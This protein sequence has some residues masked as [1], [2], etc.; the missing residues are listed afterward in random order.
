MGYRLLL[1]GPPASGKGTQASAL[2]VT[3]RVPHVSTGQLFRDTARAG[4]ERG[5]TVRSFI[6]K[7]QLVP[8]AITIDV[9]RAWLAGQGAEPEFIFDG[10]PRTLP[11]ATAFDELM[12]QRE[13]RLGKV[14]FLDVDEEE[15]LARVLGRLGC[16]NCGALYHA[17]FSP[18]REAGHCDRCGQALRRRADDTEATVRER[19]RQY[20]DLSRPVVEHY[21]A[22]GLLEEIAGGK[23]K[24]QV[25]AEL[26]RIA[27]S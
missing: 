24:Q 19:L 8:D 18:P 20:R 2:S 5:D 3:L 23:P 11:Q 6:D 12:R 16:A 14:I 27:K 22:Q 7:G 17:T 21:R 10:F 1:L 26:L 13:L 15:T 4:G 9:V 25:F